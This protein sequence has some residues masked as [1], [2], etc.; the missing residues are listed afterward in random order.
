MVGTWQRISPVTTVSIPSLFSWTGL[1]LLCHLSSFVSS[2]STL[3]YASTT[4]T[5]GL[6][7]RSSVAIARWENKWPQRRTNEVGMKISRANLDDDND[8]DDGVTCDSVSYMWWPPARFP[9]NP[10]YLAIA[11]LTI[12]PSPPN[13]RHSLQLWP[14]DH[15]S[16]DLRLDRQGRHSSLA[17]GIRHRCHPTGSSLCLG[18]GDAT[19]M[20]TWDD[21]TCSPV[22]YT[23]LPIDESQ[24][25]PRYLSATTDQVTATDLP[26]SSINAS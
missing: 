20:M 8:P 17:D 14:L 5:G 21:T 2:R 4:N 22:H 1:A 7:T 25:N 23:W 13:E 3:T 11:N 19:P 16:G 12:A 6:N 24:E 10:R 26:Q 9:R 15:V 18:G